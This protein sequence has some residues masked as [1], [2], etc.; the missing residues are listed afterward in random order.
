MKPHILFLTT[1][2]PPIPGVPATGAGMRAWGLA[3]GLISAGFERV[4]LAFAADAIRG[5]EVD[6]SVVPWVSTVERGDIDAFIRAERPDAIVFQHWGLMSEMKSDPGCPVAIDLA[7]PHL[8]ER[9]LWGSRD[10]DADLREKLTALSRAD[11]VT[12]SGVFQRNYFLAYLLQA[13]FDARDRELCQVIPFSLS[14]ELPE[15]DP[16]RSGSTLF[17]GG[18]FLPWQDPEA[19]LRTALSALDK[20]GDGRLIF[21]GGPH[22]SGDVSE[23]RFDALLDALGSHPR[24]ERHGLLPFE[25]MLGLMRGSSVALDLMPRNAERL[26]AFPTRT[27]TCLWAGLPVVHN[28]YDELAEPIDHAKAGWTMDEGDQTGLEALLVRLLRNRTESARRAEAAQKLVRASYTWDRTIGPLAAWCAEPKPRADKRPARVV[29]VAPAD[30]V[31]A[32]RK[33]TFRAGRVGYSPRIAVTGPNRAAWLL[34]P[35]V[36][37]IALPIS[38][39]LLVFFLFAYIAKRIVTGR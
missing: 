24:V 9:R 33:K 32:P 19:T 39:L 20:V 21:V 38:M 36:F 4:T 5:R 3:H 23:G 16:E 35:I 7:G 29:T 15:I 28:N 31:D 12:C 1:E 6:L 18:M 2:P 37:L 30:V 13:G 34:S 10:T 17:Y 26:L 27:V 22:P 8:L 11:F 25:K 14:P